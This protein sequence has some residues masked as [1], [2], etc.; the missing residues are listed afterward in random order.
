MEVFRKSLSA[1]FSGERRYAIPLFQRPYVWTRELQWE[2]LWEDILGCTEREESAPSTEPPVHFLGAIVI[3]QRRSWGDE[4]LAH[5]VIDGQ[6]RLTTFQILFAA[7]RDLARAHGER[8]VSSWLEG[9][10]TNVNAIADPNVERFKVW[11]T[12][13]DSGQF[14]LVSSGGSILEIEKAHPC[15]YRRKRLQ[16]RPRMV[17]AYAFFHEVLSEWLGPIGGTGAVDRLRLLRRVI[18]KR[19]Q[20]V[21]IELAGEE[22]PQ[23]IFETLNARGVPLL[24]S[25]L[26]RN[27]IFQR[28]GGPEEADRLHATYWT[29]FEAPADHSNPD[30]VRFWE[31]EERQGRLYRARLD[32]FVQHYLSMKLGNDVLTTR[33]FPE[34]KAWIEKKSPFG[35]VEAELRDLVRFADH[36]KV[37]LQPTTETVLGRFAGHLRTLDVSTVYPLVL[38]LMGNQRLTEDDRTGIL[39]DIESF[40]VRRLVCGRPTKSYNKLFLQV[41]RDFEGSQD[42]TRKSFQ[43]LLIA[44]EGENVDWPDD[45]TFRSSWVAFDAYRLIKAARVEMLLLAVEAA[46]RDE[47]TEQVTIKGDLTIEHVMPQT[48]QPHWPL[49]PDLDVETATQQREEVI[50]DL[51]NLTLLTTA[52]NSTVSNGPADKKLP[53]IA[54]QSSLKLNAY[55][56]GRKTWSEKDIRER[57]A[58]LF[59]AALRVWPR[60][61]QQ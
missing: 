54:L 17:E 9:L 16:P 29:G 25:D 13:R 14:Q 58:K 50:H 39:M 42:A 48:W 47:K 15:V 8:Q 6:Q 37:L 56:Q 27:Y 36:F 19:L 38:G 45:Q 30:G 52:L 35:N 46:L 1:V 3:Q 49:P 21:S 43:S 24:A 41:L 53:E 34:Y 2:P 28:A 57:G 4:I 12:S 40:L 32:L 5:D 44:G 51:G 22:D 60:P 20:L 11:P 55:F 10:T 7:L 33:L 26:L 59:Q 18:D 23:A 61:Q 31:V